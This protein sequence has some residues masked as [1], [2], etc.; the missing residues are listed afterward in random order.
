MPL[1]PTSLTVL[2]RAS[3]TRPA[4]EPQQY[5]TV[6]N[7]KLGLTVLSDDTVDSSVDKWWL[8]I[9]LGG[10]GVV[11]SIAAF[12]LVVAFIYRYT[13]SIAKPRSTKRPK[14]RNEELDEDG[15]GEHPLVRKGRTKKRRVRTGHSQ[16]A[17]YG[18]EAVEN[19]AETPIA[20]ESG[21]PP[22]DKGQIQREPEPAQSPRSPIP[23]P[24]PN[25][26]TAE[27]QSVQ[28]G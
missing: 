1:V 16:H 11:L 2:F 4:F 28:Q 19:E 17:Q 10:I 15:A 14:T 5:Q 9:L 7:P 22:E 8:G 27:D 13:H 12:S 23:D 3:A 26:D 25:P 20:K 24:K 18:H 21:P 6:S